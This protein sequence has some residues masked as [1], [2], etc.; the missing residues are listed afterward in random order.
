MSGSEFNAVN[1]GKSNSRNSDKDWEE[2]FLI[3]Q[4]SNPDFSTWP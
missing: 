1:Q 4:F 2:F 3:E